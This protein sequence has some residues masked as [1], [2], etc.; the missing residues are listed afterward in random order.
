MAILR[1]GSVPLAVVVL[2]ALV[3][4]LAPAEWT[5]GEGIR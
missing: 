3:A 5:L 2:G 1:H 4:R